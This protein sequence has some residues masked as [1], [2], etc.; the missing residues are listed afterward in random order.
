MGMG[1]TYIDVAA[2]IPDVGK[3][4]PAEWSGEAEG[5]G[6]LVIGHKARE[7]R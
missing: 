2:D 1:K 7:G 3:S 5:Y 6:E 4:R